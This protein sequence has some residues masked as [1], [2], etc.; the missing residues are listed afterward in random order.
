MPI[1]NENDEI[2][3]YK[4]ILEVNQWYIKRINYLWMEK[5]K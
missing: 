5:S 4:D 3:Y 2:I 1:I